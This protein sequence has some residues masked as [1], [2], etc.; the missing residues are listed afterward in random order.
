MRFNSI[1]TGLLML[2]IAWGC[3]SDST[4]VSPETIGQ[5]GSM[6]RFAIVESRLYIVDHSK[7]S[8][9]NITENSFV[10]LDEVIVGAG[11]ETIFALGNYLYLGASDAMYIYSIEDRDHP[12]FVFR[13]S[14]IVSCDP[15]VVQGNRAYV[16]LRSG[17]ACNRGDNAL[18]ILDISN[19][20]APILIANYPMI[21]PHGL[22]VDDLRLFICEGKAGLKMFDISDEKDIKLLHHEQS[23]FAYDV[24]A[25]NEVL[26]LTGEDGIFQYRYNQTEKSLTEISKIPVNRLEP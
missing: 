6:A 21:S 23:V 14:H 8:V 19:P 18:E 3:N 24:I 2:C 25:R 7:I 10:Q 20:Y 13:Y 22:A 12:K 9:F 4:M 5:G 17:T 11:V 15:V 1:Y 16:T 26:T